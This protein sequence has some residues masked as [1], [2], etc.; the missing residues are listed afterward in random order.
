MVKQIP[1]I[2]II[3][4]VYNAEK[5]LPKCLN[6]LLG[7][8][9]D[10]IEI[11]AVNDGSTDKSLDILETYAKKD[12]RIRVFSHK[13]QG[14]SSTRQVGLGHASASAIMFCDA[15]DWYQ[16]TMCQ[17]MLH[18]LEKHD[19]DIVK[20]NIVPIDEEEDLKRTDKKSYYR[21]PYR[22]KYKITEKNI[23]KIN[24]SL[25]SS[26]FKM[27]V[28]RKYAISFPEKL[29][30]YEDDAFM[31]MY[32]SIAQNIFFLDRDLYCYWRRANSLVP[33]YSM[34]G[35]KNFDRCLLMRSVYSFLQEHQLWVKE[36]KIFLKKYLFLFRTSFLLATEQQKKELLQ[37][38][39]LFVMGFYDSKEDTISS[40]D[41]KI[42]EAIK[43]LDLITLNDMWPIRK[44]KWKIAG[45]TIT[46]M[47]LF[48]HK[49][50]YQLFGFTYRTKHMALN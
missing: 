2:S 46:Q 43:R 4:P 27:A 13:N 50:I 16:S 24:V 23:F 17:E 38:E 11:I 40:N 12:T 34:G 3:V 1:Q 26:I 29:R 42:M 21:I 36:K 19:V 20:C 45:F 48:H 41:R 30:S 18:V 22:G 25:A 14:V 8:T 33:S 39:Q 5:Y 15:D 49:R 44:E 6:A 37:H 7:Q 9:F 35:L 10:N 32:L 31:L 28:I 47:H